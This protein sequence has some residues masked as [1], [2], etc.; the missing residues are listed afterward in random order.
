MTDSKNGLRTRPRLDPRAAW[1]DRTALVKKEAEAERKATEIKTAR[2]K[3]LRLEKEAADK[4]AA[5]PEAA[6]KPRA[7]KRVLTIKA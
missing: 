7:R 4:A 6:P 2:L 1:E 5:P 3:I